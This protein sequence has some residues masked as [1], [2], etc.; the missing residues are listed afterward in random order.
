MSHSDER[1]VAGGAHAALPVPAPGW[2][3]IGT[4]AVASVG[5][6]VDEVFSSLCAGKTGLAPLRG[7]DRT[8][9]RAVH[10]YEIDDRPEPGRDRPGRATEFL[11]DA[12]AQALAQAGLPEQL[13]CI[14]VLIG[15][16]LREL[17]SAELW[18]RGDADLREED[19]HFGTE[20][21]RRFGAANTHTFSNACSASLYALALASDLLAE[22]A[23]DTVV[24]AG[25]DTI[26][27]S[28][29]GLLDRVHPNPVDAV[30]PFDR[31]RRGV[32]MGDGAAAIVL[33]SA[34][35]PAL[36]RLLA[37]SVNCDAYHVTAPAAAGITAAIRDAHARAGIR[38]DQVDLLFA[39]G[40][41]TLLN[42][43]TEA[44]ALAEVFGAVPRPLVTAIKSMTGHTSGSSGLLSL[45]VAVE[46][47]RTGRVPPVIGLFEPVKEAD[48]FRF[49]RDAEAHVQPRLAQVEAFGF[50]G[51]N[52][53]ALLSREH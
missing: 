19:L 31:D 17:R 45:V 39:H 38:P 1:A 4:G 15:T 32:L 11:V 29:F 49:V 42:D 53:V 6:G 28:M 16:G 22:E 33:T 13:G 26:T 12:I 23:A 21:A 30:R 5:R 34:A 2:A 8:R 47:L 3:V 51:V 20:L 44:A 41:G 18:S 48:G 50:G 9:Y 43:E 27:E 46:S 35:L 10:A 40:T 52:A 37:V 25:V 24:V 14:P 7:F 36:A